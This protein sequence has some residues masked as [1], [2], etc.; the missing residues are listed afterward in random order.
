MY[1]TSRDERE[2]RDLKGTKNIVLMGLALGML[3]YAVPR[4]DLSSESILPTVF[5]IAW[6]AFALLIIAAH[7]HELLGVDEEAREEME[8]VKRMKKWQLEQ[9][10]QGKRKMLQFKK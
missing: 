3:F 7:L 5:G 4:L 9:M 6:I 10:V 8:K 2:E 1:C